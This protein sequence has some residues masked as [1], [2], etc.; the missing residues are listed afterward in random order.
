MITV[1]IALCLLLLCWGSFLNVV[2]YRLIHDGSFIKP[3]SFCPHCHHTL[4]WY[5]LIPLFSWIVLRG[6][7]RYCHKS[8]SWLY[9]FIELVTVLFLSLLIFCVPSNY[10]FAYFIF[11]SALI[12]TI[13]SDL[14]TML[15]SRFVSLFLVPLGFLFSAINLLPITLFE[16]I[17]GAV[18]GF[19]LLYSIGKIFYLFTKKEGLGQGDVDLLS[20]IGSFL[21]FYGCWFSLLLGSI[22]GSIIGLVHILYTRSNT[23][24][25]IPFGPFLAIGAILFVLLKPFLPITLFT[26]L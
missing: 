1:V 18:F 7:C 16:S 26:S 8:I 13:R 23:S 17:W 20:F 6:H 11:F 9:P 15:I 5:D 24:H 10:L 25:K 4:A 2:A 14:E 22:L 19:C 12:V 3:R 21:G